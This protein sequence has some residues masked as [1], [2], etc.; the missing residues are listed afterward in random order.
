VLQ[1]L[2]GWAEPLP[3]TR[4]QRWLEALEG[5]PHIKATTNGR[6]FYADTTDLLQQKLP[7]L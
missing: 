1:P 6:E 3:G 2:R 4:W 5:N 7:N